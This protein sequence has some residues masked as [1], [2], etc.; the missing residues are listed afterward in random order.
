MA[1]FTFM[2]SGSDASGDLSFY[3]L[4]VGDNVPVST[5]VQKNA[6]PRSI[7]C[8][9]NG[10]SFLVKKRVL[11]DAGRRVQAYIRLDALPL[12][13]IP[14]LMIANQFGSEIVSVRIN[15]A[16]HV[17]LFV[18]GVQSGADSATLSVATWYRITLSYTITNATTNTIKLWVAGAN[19]VTL[20]NVA[21]GAISSSD[22]YLGFI[23][24]PGLTG[25][26]YLYIDD[27]M[28]DDSNA[29]TDPGVM[30]ITCKH[31]VA[32]NVNNFDTAIGA[33]PVNRWLNVN[34]VPL[35]IVNG[36]KQAAASAVRENY[37]LEALAVGDIDLT[38]LTIVGHSGW[39]FAS[40]ANKSGTY[41]QTLGKNA[42]KTATSSLMITNHGIATVTGNT[43]VVAF[44]M[45]NDATDQGGL[46]QCTDSVGNIYQ[47]AIQ[48]SGGGNP[49]TSVRTIL[50]Y[51][52]NAVSIPA[53]GTITIKHPAI[54]SRVGIAA[55]FGGISTTPLDQTASGNGTNLIPSSGI[56]GTTTQAEEIVI[57]AIGFKGNSFHWKNT[58][59]NIDIGNTGTVGGD[60]NIGIELQYNLMTSTGTAICDGNITGTIIPWSAVVATFKAAGVSLGTPKITDNAVDTTLTLTTVPALYQVYVTSASFPSNVSGIGML[61]CGEP[62]DTNL[63]E[64]GTL[65]SYHP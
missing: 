6:G 32:N 49:G 58:V 45:D 43:I 31:P 30:L 20:S 65:I 48:K 63:F 62:I 56:T 59:D 25:T 34:E 35:N 29:V 15:T 28:V 57:G 61:S 1:N 36:W 44:A 55:E 37:T 10:S 40:R 12:V 2:E 38:G 50:F 24:S 14:I 16:G 52:Q 54:L 46:V 51:C 17:Q 9:G 60:P 23:E 64:C 11:A 22:L 41:I 26:Q 13:P 19:L 42:S 47:T 53:L 8:P 7:R 33:N 5:T 4:V 27:V 18:N 39:V 21:L 3:D